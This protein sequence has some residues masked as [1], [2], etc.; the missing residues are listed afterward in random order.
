MAI[1]DYYGRDVD[2]Q[3]EFDAPAAWRGGALAGAVATVST[4]AVIL[5]V[6]ASLF[7]DTIAGMY[8]LEGSMAVGIGAHLVHGT[9]FGVLFA[10]VLSDPGIMGLTR[11][12]WKS[13]VAGVIFG[14]VLAA[15]ATGFVLPAWTQF[16]GL[17]DPPT[18]PYVTGTLLAWH[19]LYGAVLG[20]VFPF[21]EQDGKLRAALTE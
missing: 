1:K 8:G 5:P 4:M 10:G 11:W 6:E 7:S 18:M 15:M 19:V 2:E 13:V 16:V 20:L 12:L 17:S 14:V 3:S 9:L 21:A